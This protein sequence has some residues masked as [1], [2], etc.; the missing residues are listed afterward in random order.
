MTAEPVAAR[1]CALIRSAVARRFGVTEREMMSIRRC[2]G[3]ARPRQVAMFLSYRLTAHS[4]AQIARV[5]DRD[6]TTVLHAIR[7][8][9]ALCEADAGLRDALRELRAE[10][11][12]QLDPDYVKAVAS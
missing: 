5:F 11:L 3:V 2:R 8:V 1:P 4:L 12:P 10:L 7:T 9:E 6:H